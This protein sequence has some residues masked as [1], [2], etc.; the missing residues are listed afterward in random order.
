M[1]EL[2][3]SR[4]RHVAAHHY[5]MPGSK[6]NVISWVAN[7]GGLRCHHAGNSCYQTLSMQH[8]DEG[9]AVLSLS[10]RCNCAAVNGHLPLPEHL[11]PVRVEG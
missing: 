11:P 6:H 10:P 5:V 9:K 2:C 1:Y 8:N 3:L 4:N 7:R